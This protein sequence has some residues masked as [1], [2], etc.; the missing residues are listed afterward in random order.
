MRA[1]PS[2]ITASAA[3]CLITFVVLTIADDLLAE[4]LEQRCA[5]VLAGEPKIARLSAGM[6]KANYA[7]CRMLTEV[8]VR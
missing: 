4:H 6:I 7:T 5:R 2:R 3:R 8:G 1:E